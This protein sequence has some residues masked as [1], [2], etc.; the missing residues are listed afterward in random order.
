MSFPTTTTGEVVEE[1]DPTPISPGGTGEI[2]GYPDFVGNGDYHLRSGSTAINRGT[3][4]GVDLDLDGFDRYSY[5]DVDMGAYEYNAIPQAYYVRVTGN[6]ANS[7]RTRNRA[8]RTI[9]H[10]M[11]NVPPGALVLVGAGT[12]RESAVFS[13]SGSPDN[14]TVFEADTTGIRTGDAGSLIMAPASG[15]GWS[16][17]MDGRSM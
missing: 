2:T 11:A 3:D 12:Y 15:G 13:A 4:A 16:C 17:R 6:N 1:A 8:W 10:A 14:P 9:S 7:G 5:G